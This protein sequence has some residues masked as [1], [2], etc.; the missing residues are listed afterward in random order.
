MLADN[1]S[2][3]FISGKPD[4]RWNDGNLHTLGQLLGSNLKPLTPPLPTIASVNPSPVTVG[5][6]TLTVNG[7][8]FTAGSVISFDG[9]ALAQHTGVIT[10]GQY[11]GLVEA[12]QRG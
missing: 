12:L 1:G 10:M 7:S 4:L 8:G 3:W 2:A 5:N 11:A 9:V 6:F